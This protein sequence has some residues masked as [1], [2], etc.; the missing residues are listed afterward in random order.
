MVGDWDG[1]K[2][3]LEFGAEERAEDAAAAVSRAV[4]AYEDYGLEEGGRRW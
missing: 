4:A 1:G 3:V 2:V